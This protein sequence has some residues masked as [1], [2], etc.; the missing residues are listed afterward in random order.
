MNP[1][2]QLRHRCGQLTLAACIA[3]AG[4][5]TQST[6]PKLFDRLGG[7]PAITAVVDKT[8]DSAAHDPRTSRSFDGVKL[9]AVKQSVVAQICEATGG[10]CKYK[11]DSMR[12]VHR[13]LDITSAEFDAFVQQLIATL[14]Q[15]KVGER[16]KHDLLQILA[17]MKTDIVTK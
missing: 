8:L 6:E 14:D 13:G 17:P 10:P 7:L 11:G 3:L 12:E 9:A 2:L 4:C 15:F 16:E 5:A 1:F